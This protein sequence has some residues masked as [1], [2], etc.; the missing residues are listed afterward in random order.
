MA[1]SYNNELRILR[2]LLE[3]EGTDTFVTPVVNSDKEIIIAANKTIPISAASLPLPAGASTETTLSSILTELQLKADL[4]ET[5][6]IS[7]NDDTITATAGTQKRIVTIDDNV[8][9]LLE[10]IL[11]QL[12]INNLHLA[13][14]TDNYITKQE[15]E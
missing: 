6:P 9:G 8:I 10:N 14:I 11:K 7:I 2:I 13:L 12:K 1:D 3:K 5:Q 4:T 15:V